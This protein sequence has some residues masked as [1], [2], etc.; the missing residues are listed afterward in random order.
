AR[1]IKLPQIVNGRVGRPDD[2]DVYRIDGRA[3]EEV[4][5]EV[6]ARRLNSPLDSLLQLADADGRV[7]A[8]ND[9]HD[10]Q[11]TGL[12]THHADSWLRARLPKDGAYYVRLAD[13]QH[14]GGEDYGYRL[15]LSP[16]QPDFA[17]RATPSTLNVPAGRAV[18]LTVHVLRKDGYDGEILLALKDAPP[19]FTLAGGRIA[20]GRDQVR[21]TLEAPARAID[22]PV[23]I[24]LEG[25]ARIGG[26]W[27]SRPVVPA[28]DMMQAFA[29]WH[30][31]PSQD[32][33]VAIRGARFRM[34]PIQPV[35]NGPVRI[36]A[37]GTA[38]VQIRAPRFPI[39]QYL[40]LELNDP[41]KGVI[42]QDVKAVPGGLTLTVKADVEAAKP[43]FADN[44]IVEMISDRTGGGAKAKAAAPN[45]RF[46]IGVLPAIPFEIVRQ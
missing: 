7:V 11:D 15:R 6:C 25:R 37:G 31:V 30:L 43:G 29:Y 17:L 12:L 36:P 18:P 33:T 14:H 44:L 35:I 20:P 10:E 3:G 41:P 32:L 8:W 16:P 22:R 19:G 39:P 46:S 27:L 28:E 45:Q 34:P 1:R 2:V 13:A 40:K 9:D 42:L 23:V 21:L 4:V 24:R 38:Q 26:Q 5:A